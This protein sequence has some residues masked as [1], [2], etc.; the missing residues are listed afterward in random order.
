LEAEASLTQERIQEETTMVFKHSALFA[1]VAIS[2]LAGF[3]GISL[4]ADTGG[5]AP[6]NTPGMP[7]YK[8][9]PKAKN[10]VRP[11]I[12]VSSTDASSQ[13]YLQREK[14]GADK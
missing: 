10:E 7:G 5:W 12:P 3:S 9:P 4:A 13:S 8:E 11:Q 1:V 2:A 6:P 14:S